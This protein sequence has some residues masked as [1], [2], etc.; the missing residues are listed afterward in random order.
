M[1]RPTPS[2]PDPALLGTAPFGSAEAGRVLRGVRVV[3]ALSGGADSVSL[4][5]C[6]VRLRAWLGAVPPFG[7]AAAHFN[8][9]IRGA[10]S[11]ADERFAAALCGR[12]GIPFHS[13][14]RDVPAAAAETGESLEMA[15][16]RLRLGFLERACAACGAEAVATGHT[17]DDQAELFFLRLKRGSSSRG[18]GGMAPLGPWSENP[19]RSVLRPLL[20]ARHAAL[21]DWLR[22]EG[23]PWREDSTNG[24]DHADRN[25][26]RHVVL[27]AAEA[28]FGP[29]FVATLGRTMATL[30]DDDA[31]LREAASAGGAPDPCAPPAPAGRAAERAEAWA[32]LPPA[33]A[34]RRIASAL[35]ALGADPERVTLRAIDGVRALL[36]RTGGGSVAVG[37]GVVAAVRRGSLSLERSR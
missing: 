23:L 35:Y 28:A 12:L 22:A 31:A 9:G 10:E 13:E 16:R 29:A 19:E 15:A 5:H 36:S 17:L 11:D 18:L 25:R 2:L 20:G 1:S 6:L 7:L 34:R 26:I 37:S 30:R 24:E 21:R 32:R 4:L 33:L 27:P 14:R 8:H 3:V